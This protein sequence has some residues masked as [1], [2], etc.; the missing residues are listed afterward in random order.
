MES[1]WVKSLALDIREGNGKRKGRLYDRS[2][3]IRAGGEHAAKKP[4]KIN[5]WFQGATHFHKIEI[6]TFSSVIKRN[7]AMETRYFSIF[8]QVRR[9]SCERGIKYSPT[10]HQ[11]A[12]GEERKEVQLLSQGCSP[13]S[14]KQGGFP[15]ANAVHRAG[16]MCSAKIKGSRVKA[17]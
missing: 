14:S 9:R 17:H 11:R 5:T 16:Y 7:T 10:P 4:Q 15:K 3:Y 12:G 6:C 2:N 13:S 8:L 1:T